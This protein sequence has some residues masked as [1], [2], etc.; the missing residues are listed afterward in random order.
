VSTGASLWLRV[1][2]GTTA[3][4]LDNGSEQAVRGDA[5]WTARS[6]S[7]LI[8]AEA[9]SVVFG[10]LL[11][12]GGAVSVRR[13]RLDVS[14]PI[15]SDIPPSAAAKAV[16]D[17][18]FSIAKKNSL[19]RTEV[20]W[21]VVEPK[22]RALAAGAEHSADVYP[23][24]RYLLSQLG[25][26]HSFFMPPSQ[27]TEFRT[28]GAQNPTPEVRS[29][30]RGI[31]YIS[32]PGYAGAEAT[33]MRAYATRMHDSLASTIASVSCGGV[34]DLRPDT[35]GNMWPMLAGLKPFLGRGGLGTF[36]SP[37]GSGPSWVAGQG[38]GVEPPSTLA[39]LESAWVAVLTGPRTASS[40]EA[41]T[42]SFR[43][44]PR[45]R[46]FGQPTAGLSTANG[47]FPLSDGAMIML[48][49]AVDADRTGQRY[50]DKVTPDVI[51]DAA[52]GTD[53]TTLSAAI[54]WLRQSSACDKG[55]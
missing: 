41:V 16:L 42:I 19:R 15:A 8:P 25:D 46:S 2:Q 55:V 54:Q 7:M 36:E 27:S 49:T 24:I 50:G 38:V 37:T 52:A 31:G 48:T 18:A 26:H 12:G 9:S 47:T 21:D 20:A 39:A 32:V 43:G 11:Q 14:G 29:L 53:D 6:M 23:A 22:V 13:L 28:G 4:M 44:R 45:T 51:V 30:P 5:D 34:V 3:L 33:A 35:G 17:E 1:D 40:G 10:V